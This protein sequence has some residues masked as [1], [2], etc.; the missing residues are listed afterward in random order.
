MLC[1]LTVPPAKTML[2]RN[3][4][5]LSNP[6]TKV[7]SVAGR[8]REHLYSKGRWSS[9]ATTVS[10]CH[11]QLKVGFGEISLRQLTIQQGRRHQWCKSVLELFESAVQTGIKVAQNRSDPF[12]WIATNRY[13]LAKW[14]MEGTSEISRGQPPAGYDTGQHTG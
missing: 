6:A 12:F 3:A 9:W 4:A 8:C 1:L 7:L 5:A 10:H 2:S 14:S 11:L 13:Y